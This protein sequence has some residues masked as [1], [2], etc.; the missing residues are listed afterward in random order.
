MFI[1]NELLLV[2]KDFSGA[3]N[4]LSN[5]NVVKFLPVVIYSICKAGMS[6]IQIELD[7]IWSLVNR[8][9]LT[10]ECVYYLTLMSSACFVLKHVDSNKKN[11]VKL[12]DLLIK[13]GHALNEAATKRSAKN[14]VSFLACPMFSYM[15]PGL[16]DIYLPDEKHQTIKI[17]TIP[18]KPLSKCREVRELIA[19]KFKVF[20]CVEYALYFLENGVEYKVRDEEQPLEI[21]NTKLKSGIRIKFIFRKKNSNLVWSK[22]IE[23]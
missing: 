9:L 1:I 10:N 5:L 17:K 16:M 6:S 18:V 14:R 15:E 19:A 23:V 7:Y 20:N 2:S 11:L 3:V 13:N 12:T 8:G 22:T 21:K 4:D